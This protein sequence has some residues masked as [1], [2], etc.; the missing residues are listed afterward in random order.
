MNYNN[1]LNKSLHK[2]FSSEIIYLN[3]LEYETAK[4]H[5]K[6]TY[7]QYYLS[8]LKMNNLF[9]FS[10]FPNKDYNSR[11]IK[12]FLFFFFF[13]LSFTINTLFFTDSTIHKIYEDKGIF[14]ISY[15]IPQIF[16]S[17][18]IS[19]FI[20][21]FIKYFALSQ[22]NVINLKKR[23]KI[24]NQDYSKKIFDVLNV[25]FFVYFI[26]SFICLIV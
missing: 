14:N 20:S 26:F 13:G 21:T 5:D 10:F 7:C 9:I 4:I 12:I 6:R 15:Q 25:K 19:V 16:Y 1:L 24:K 18:M 11:I 3:N 2:N 23:I 17:S 8:L 22:Q